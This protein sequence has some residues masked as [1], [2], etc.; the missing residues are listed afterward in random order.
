MVSQ[1]PAI[2]TVPSVQSYLFGNFMRI[3]VGCLSS[4]GGTVKSLRAG[5]LFPAGT[6]LHT[7]LGPIRARSDNYREIFCDSDVAEL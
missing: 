2:F 5:V 4:S 6:I 1:A 7:Y 3:F